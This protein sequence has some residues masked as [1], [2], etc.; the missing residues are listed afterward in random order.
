MGRESQSRESG[1]APSH[2]VGS[3]HGHSL[4]D[5][6]MG[7]VPFVPTYTCRDWEPT[8][9]SK[10]GLLSLE[11]TAFTGLFLDNCDARDNTLL[12]DPTHRS[13]SLGI[14]RIL[15]PTEATVSPL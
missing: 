1:T 13:N 15:S 7:L 2:L 14:R 5:S 12:H 9:V 10:Y 3:S 6:H 11:N 4:C 8:S